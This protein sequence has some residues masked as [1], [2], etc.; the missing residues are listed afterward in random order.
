MVGALHELQAHTPFIFRTVDID[1][2]P[3][4][5]RKYAGDIPVLAAGEEVLCRYYLDA[6]VV[7]RYLNDN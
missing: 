5:Q 7:F 3:G 6:D 2:D 1:S 4:L